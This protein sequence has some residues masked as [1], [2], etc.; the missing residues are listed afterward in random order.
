MKQFLIKCK[1]KGITADT[2]KIFACITMLIDHI[3]AAILERGLTE[4]YQQIESLDI[5]L[6]LIGRGAFPIFCFLLVEGYLHTSNKWKYLLRMGVFVLI[7][8]IVFDL[9]MFGMLTPIK[10]NVYCTLFLGLATMIF[11]EM[12]EN[13]W[14][15][16]G[17]VAKHIP[18][19]LLCV[20]AQFLHTDYG[21]IGV[22]LIYIMYC[23]RKNR[24]L[25]CI[26]GFA[27]LYFEPTCILGFIPIYFY[28]GKRTN[29]I[30]KYIFYVF[31]P[32]HL[33][34]LYGVHLLIG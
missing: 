4:Q 25:Q 22:V 9:S 31:Y 34:I 29:R 33:L 10:Q 11:S 12:I 8:E 3:G 26:C 27:C 28:N 5:I 7:S 32:I 17:K 23:A 24:L 13:K 1:K 6:R 15:T 18:V 2:I 19:V 20:V 14:E 30:N 16:F 21:A